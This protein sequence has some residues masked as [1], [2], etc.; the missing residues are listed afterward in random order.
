MPTIVVA[1]GFTALFGSH[2]LLNTSLMDLFGLA[3]PPIKITNTLTII[4]MAHAFYNYAIVIRIV[5]ALWSN[6]DPHLEETARMLGAGRLRTFG[7]ITLPLLLPAIA[8]SALMAFAFSFTSFGVVLILG[9]A[10]FATLEVGIYEL[11]AKLFRMPLAAVLS[12]VQ[13]VFTYL[14]LLL[15][16]RLQ[17]RSTVRLDL[18]PQSSTVRQRTHMGDRVFIAGMILA[19]LVILSPLMAL[20]E[21]GFSSGDGYSLAHF[22]R[23]FSNE[24]GSYFYL[25]PV[26]IMWNSVRLALATV[27]VSL[28]LGT[29]VAYFLSRPGRRDRG[30]FDA[31]FMLPL[32]VSAVTLGFGFIVALNRPPIDL[33][34]SWIILVIAHSLVAYPFVIRSLLPVLRGL[35]PYLREAAV[36]LGASAPRVFIS[37]DLPITA[38]ALMVGATFAFAISMGEFGASLLLVRPDFTTMPVAIFRFLGQPGA[39]NLGQALAMSSLLMAVVALGFI[40]IERFRYRNVGEF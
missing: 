12:L 5:S 28:V 24:S 31:L 10:Q 40:V 21:R 16:V 34:G 26:T 8:S 38:R 39:A 25:S 7:Q 14:F 2:G 30:V 9:G 36:V 4:L 18:K 20:V 13:I 1:M 23:L 15:Y 33:R 27:T 35:S 11:T 19:I 29:I 6:L 32:G 37:I 22:A 17:D 3:V